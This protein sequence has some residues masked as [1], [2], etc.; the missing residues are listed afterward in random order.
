MRIVELK[1][2]AF[3]LKNGP[4]EFL[5]GLSSNVP[6]APKNAFLD[7]RG[8][9]VA[10]FDQ[11][12]VDP[13]RVLIAVEEPFAGR[14]A[15]HL[16]KFLKLSGAVLEK[17]DL[18]V[19]HDLDADYGVSPADFVIP[20]RRGR[21]VLTR[22][23]PASNVSE[24]E[25]TAFRLAHA[26]PVQGVDFDRE[27]V[28]NLDNES[29]ISF[30][31]GCFL[32]QEIVARVHHRGRPPRRLVVKPLDACSEEEARAMTSKAP[33]PAS[34]KTIGFVFTSNA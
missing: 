34:G 10:V 3:F 18:S 15:G 31:K 4:A 33:D 6:E 7:A 16:D 19:Y 2:K 22:K 28:L 29:L 32:G 5:R 8:Q 1:K 17:T 26:M 11:L 14:L 21:L 9:I 20:Q 30:T 23:R 25:Y 27:M 24:A 13:D 12:L